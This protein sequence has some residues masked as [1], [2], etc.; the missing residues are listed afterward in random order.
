MDQFLTQRQKRRGS[1]HDAIY[2]IIS[3]KDHNY[4]PVFFFSFQQ[5]IT[6]RVKADCGSYFRNYVHD[7]QTNMKMERK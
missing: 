4:N 2:H 3:P 5:F 6:R 1:N 7:T